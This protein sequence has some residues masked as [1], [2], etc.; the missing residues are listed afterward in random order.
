MNEDK[1]PRSIWRNLAILRSGGAVLFLIGVG[2]L[3]WLTGGFGSIDEVCSNDTTSVAASPNGTLKAV[4]FRRDCG[5]T[6][7]TGTHVSILSASR[8]LPNLAGNVLAQGGEPIVV[9]RWIDDQH[10]SI[11]GAGADTAFV[12]LSEFRGVRISYD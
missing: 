2:A 1:P 4:L 10:L 9:V 12:H 3:Y 8:A 5:A 6:T 7:T 11:S